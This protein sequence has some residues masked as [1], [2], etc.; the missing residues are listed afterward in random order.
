MTDRVVFMFDRVATIV[1]GVLRDVL[2]F[3]GDVD[4]GNQCDTEVD[5]QAVDV[6]EAEESQNGED[7]S[8]RRE[9]YNVTPVQNVIKQVKM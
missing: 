1:G 2:V 7:N 5:S 8:T 6:E 4:H 3:L 9:L